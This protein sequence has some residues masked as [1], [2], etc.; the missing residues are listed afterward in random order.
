MS[1]PEVLNKLNH[2]NYKKQDDQ[3]LSYS[4]VEVSDDNYDYI[5]YKVKKN[6]QQPQTARHRPAAHVPTKFEGPLGN[7]SEKSNSDLEVS[8][9]SPDNRLRQNK[10][11]KVIKMQK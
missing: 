7:I 9:L 8:Q 2:G 10:D 1:D 5:V 4:E 11:V 6:K 3:Y